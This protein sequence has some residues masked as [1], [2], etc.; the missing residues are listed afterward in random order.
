M[1]KNA[2]IGKENEPT[3]AELTDALGP[4]KAVWDRL[5]TDLAGEYGLDIRE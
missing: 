1:A 5:L 3:D 4:A 2:F